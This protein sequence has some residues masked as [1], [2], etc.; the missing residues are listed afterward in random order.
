MPFHHKS[1][2]ASHGILN[3]AELSHTLLGTI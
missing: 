3:F 1:L 2:I